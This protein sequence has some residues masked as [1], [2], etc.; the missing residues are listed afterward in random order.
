[1]GDDERTDRPSPG[2]EGFIETTLRDA[3]I[4]GTGDDPEPPEQPQGAAFPRRGDD[5][6]AE[7][8]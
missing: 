3:T 6:D 2:Q 8:S 4:A 7:D 1:M 5:A